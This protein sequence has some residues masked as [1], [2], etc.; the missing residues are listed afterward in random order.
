MV[1]PVVP[2]LDPGQIPQRDGSQAQGVY[3]DNM[4]YF[5]GELPDVI[6]GMNDLGDWMN[7]TADEVEA[8]RAAAAT[9][10][11]NA[12]T[13]ETNA[14]ASAASVAA[15]PSTN[16]TSTSSLTP[17]LGSKSL[18]LA[19]TG[20][21]FVVGQWVVISDSTTPTTKFLRG[22]ITAFTSGTGAMTVNVTDFAGSAAGTAWVVSLSSP[23]NNY[24]MPLDPTIVTGTSVTAVSFGDY[25]LTNT[26]A[27][28]AVTLPASPN[29][30]DWVNIDNLSGRVDGSLLR[31]GSNIEG[32]ADDALIDIMGSFRLTYID[33][34]RGWQFRALVLQ[35]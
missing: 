16:A 12:A 2:T 9:S 28:T 8:D 13:S 6:T 27:G 3:S 24:R 15:S 18:T 30:S 33:A 35:N 14:A 25:T 5:T 17:G 7:T 22:A 11:T 10:A 4:D 23:P 19:E 34:T 29:P 32:V 31:N 20:K 21:N 1:A 26:G